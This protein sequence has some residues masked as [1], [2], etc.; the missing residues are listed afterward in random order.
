MTGYTGYTCFFLMT[1][2]SPKAS[3]SWPTL[4]PVKP[5]LSRFC[6]KDALPINDLESDAIRIKVVK[7]PSLLN[8]NGQNSE[9]GWTTCIMPN[10]SPIYNPM[11]LPDWPPII[12]NTQIPVLTPIKVIQSLFCLPN[13]P[14]L[15]FMF[16]ALSEQKLIASTLSSD[17]L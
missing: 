2:H 15:V 6:G 13:Q 5:N 17:L 16:K 1:S 8:P 3:F 9:I 4:P 12:F 11:F 7:T 14:V 10:W